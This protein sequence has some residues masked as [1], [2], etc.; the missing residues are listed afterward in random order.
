MTARP[1]VVALLADVD[2]GRA[3]ARQRV[4]CRDG[5]PFTAEAAGL[6]GHT[7]DDHL[8]AGVSQL[9]AAAQRRTKLVVP[10]VRAAGADSADRRPPAEPR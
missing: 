9:A 1:E 3:G 10:Y 4:V 8:R 2:V 5:S 6:T 7:S